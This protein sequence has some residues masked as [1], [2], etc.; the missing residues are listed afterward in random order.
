MN[1]TENSIILETDLTGVE[2]HGRGKVRDVYRISERLLIVATDRIPPSI[3]FFP[4][5]FPTRG[6]S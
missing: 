1:S 4:P 5:A 3:T 6:A 2:R